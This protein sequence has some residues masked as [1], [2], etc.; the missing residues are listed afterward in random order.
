[1]V[2][3]HL[4][5]LVFLVLVVN[6]GHS[7]HPFTKSDKSKPSLS[8]FHLRPHLANPLKTGFMLAECSF[9]MLQQP[10]E[11]L[12]LHSHTCTAPGPNQSSRLGP[13]PPPLR[14]LPVVRGQLRKGLRPPPGQLGTWWRR[15]PPC[16]PNARE[17]VPKVPLGPID[18][19]DKDLVHQILCLKFWDL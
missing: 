7:T 2:K 13:L 3:K 11:P 14:V 9:N 15:N 6:E 5:H 10:S 18:L 1:M 4:D 8:R 12:N 19:S 16:P 17:G